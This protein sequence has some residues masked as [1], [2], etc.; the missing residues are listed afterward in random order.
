MAIKRHR[1]D[2][3]RN[4]R[5]V[6]L[7]PGKQ[8][9]KKLGLVWRNRKKISQIINDYLCLPFFLLIILCSRS[10]VAK[11]AAH[12]I[13]DCRH[14]WHR[15]YRSPFSVIDCRWYKGKNGVVGFVCRVQVCK[16]INLGVAR[17]RE[18]WCLLP[19]WFRCISCDIVFWWMS[20]VG[21]RVSGV[22]FDWRL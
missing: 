9:A 10:L 21:C 3:I 14:I 5:N 2:C 19:T 1:R 13:C 7:G 20:A 18:K 12:N 22:G 4:S 8:R 11:K 6:Q 17:E 15:T 16:W